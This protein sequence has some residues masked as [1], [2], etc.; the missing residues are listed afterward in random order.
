MPK[1]KKIIKKDEDK[2]ESKD[3]T[4]EILLDDEDKVNIDPELIVGDAISDDEDGD[5]DVATVDDDEVN[6]FGDRWEE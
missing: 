5:D 4:K 6:P 2:E 1:A 3:E